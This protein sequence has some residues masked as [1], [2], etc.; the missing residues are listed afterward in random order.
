MRLESENFKTNWSANE[1]FQS[2][3][4][5]GSRTLHSQAKVDRQGRER[6]RSMLGLGSGVRPSPTHSTLSNINVDSLILV[7]S[8]LERHENDS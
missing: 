8:L 5:G 2:N 3:L 1:K 7:V 6:E 4:I